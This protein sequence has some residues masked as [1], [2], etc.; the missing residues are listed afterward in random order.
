MAIA[1]MAFLIALYPPG[2]FWGHRGRDV[3]SSL[4]EPVKPAHL[5]RN[6]EQFSD[7]E[8]IRLQEEVRHLSK[9]MDRLSQDYQALSE[10]TM[11]QLVAIEASKN[12]SQWGGEAYKYG[13]K[14]GDDEEDVYSNEIVDYVDDNDPDYS[15][16]EAMPDKLTVSA[17]SKRSWPQN[18]FQSTVSALNLFPQ[19]VEPVRNIFDSGIEESQSKI[20]ELK[21]RGEV[22]T[23]SLAQVR[24]EVRATMEQ[25]LSSVLTPEQMDYFKAFNNKANRYD[26]SNIRQNVGDAPIQSSSG[27]VAVHGVGTLRTNLT[28]QQVSANPDSSEEQTVSTTK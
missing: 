28:V 5:R 26:D 19:Q 17:V 18:Q 22:T 7:K 24:E 13:E 21:S 16:S 27:A 8:L 10:W 4:S 6:G 1:A 15:A 2:T 9:K 12:S 3:L 11:D 23:E 20:A 14:D 25:K